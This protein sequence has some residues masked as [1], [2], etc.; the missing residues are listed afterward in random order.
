MKPPA[1]LCLVV[2]SIC[3]SGCALITPPDI[4]S[5]RTMVYADGTTETVKTTVR[6]P[7]YSKE[8]SSVSI[9]TN[10]VD[11]W[12]SS[13]Q[14]AKDIEGALGDTKGKLL[15][16]GICGLVIMAG[17]VVIFLRKDN[18]DGY[19]ICGIGVAS[20]AAVRFIEASAKYMGII[21]P[22]VVLAGGGYLFWLWRNGKKT[23]AAKPAK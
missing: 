12:V 19:I 21:I 9:S 3:L 10:G 15:M 4:Q 6:T 14:A 13:S 2:V 1:A 18:K 22:I 11:A 23:G 16:Y 8:G 17:I 20:F 7:R 5:E